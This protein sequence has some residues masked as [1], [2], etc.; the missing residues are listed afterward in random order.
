MKEKRMGKGSL[1]I[2]SGPFATL[3][4]MNAFRHI[5][6][7]G[8]WL[9]F[10]GYCGLTSAQT[11]T[12]AEVQGETTSSPFE[13]EQVTI[14]GKVT[15]FFGDVWYIQ[16]E[17]GPWNGLR[18]VGP[19][20]IIEPNPP[21]WN[22]PRQPEV[23]DVLE[24][25]GTIVEM[26][27]NTQMMDITDFVFVDFWNATPA[28]T[29]VTV[30]GMMDESLEGTRVRLDPVTVLTAPEDGVW[31]V[32]DATGTLTIFGVDTDDVGMD[33][34]ADGPTPGDVYRVYGA[35]RQIGDDYHLDL[36][37]IDTLSLV[38]GIEDNARLEIQLTPNP[39]TNAVKISGFEQSSLWC[40]LDA[41]GRPVRTG[42]SAGAFSVPLEGLPSGRYTVQLNVAGE[43]V[44]KPLIVE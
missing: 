24:L 3:N 21:W 37:D 4:V 12:C 7:A 8:V 34:D 42:E 23:G 29:G 22:E 33:E 1:H 18:C 13:G 40:I 43:S 31:T 36:S 32:S 6:H 20:V 25:T 28:G 14:S 2:G 35:V 44:R 16:D 11:L 26:E 27:G 10:L 17:Y 30:E 5:Q 41:M 15:V 39:A 9:A 19:D 38:V